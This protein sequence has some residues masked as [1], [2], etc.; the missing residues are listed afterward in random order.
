[1]TPRRGGRQRDGRSMHDNYGPVIWGVVA[2]A[3]DFLQL[4]KNGTASGG[5]A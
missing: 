3:G 5:D 1:M 4:S 2:S